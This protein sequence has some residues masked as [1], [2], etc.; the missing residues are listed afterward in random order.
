[1]LFIKFLNEVY[2]EKVVD[3]IIKVVSRAGSKVGPFNGTLCTKT[4]QNDILDVFQ[5]YIDAHQPAGQKKSNYYNNKVYTRFILISISTF[6]SP[7]NA[8]NFVRSYSFN[9]PLLW[10]IEHIIPQK[11]AFH[12]WSKK[13]R[14]WKNSLGNL[15]LL[16]ENTNVKISNGS[17]HLKK[18][19]ISQ[20]EKALEINDI[21]N[22]ISKVHLSKKDIKDRDENLRKQL[23]GIFF[24]RNGQLFLSKLYYF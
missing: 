16:R 19:K 22:S 24:D 1:M 17:F 7:G 11:Q 18:G 21:F 23:N 13:N 12:H 9:Q 15:T 3:D 10:Q 6:Y 8:L 14:R 5:D 2:D 20:E 4:H